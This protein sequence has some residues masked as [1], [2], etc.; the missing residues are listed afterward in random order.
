VGNYGSDGY[1]LLGWNGS[2][3]LVSLPQSTISLDQ[4]APW[5]WSS[6]T[7]ALLALESPDITSHRATCWFYGTQLRLH[8]AFP[9]SYVGTVYLYAIDWDSTVRRENVTINDGSG[10]RTAFITTDFSQGAWINAHVSVPAGGSVTITVDR[11]A[12]ANAVLSGLFLGAPSGAP[13][14]PA[15]LAATAASSSQ[16]NLSWSASAGAGS[17]QIQRS[18]DGSTGWTQVGSTSSGLSYSDTSLTGATTYFYRVTGSN[19]VGASPPSNVVSAT[20][21]TAL[22]YTQSPQG[23]W[24]GNY[25]ASAYALLGW[26]GSSDLISLPQ[27]T[28]SLDQGARWSWNGATSD[29]RALQSPDATT[30]RATC[31][32]QGTELKLHLTFSSAYS[33]ALHVYAMDWDST[34]R[35]ESVTVNDGSGPRTANI[36]TDFSQGAWVNTTINVAAGGT[37]TITVDRAGGANAVISGLFLG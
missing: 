13:S 22:T 6:S 30:R 20:T 1:G 34:A 3:D 12:G 31:W 37:V 18:P 35:R 26:N 25:G 2:T 33:G 28:L 4:G 14:A 27:A 8:L 19:S 23:T 11:T 9:S 21:G 10:P 15:G 32:F 7:S 16:I 17:Y 29:V 24:V 36:T 5:S